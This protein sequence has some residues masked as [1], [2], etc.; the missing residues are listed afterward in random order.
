MR[1]YDPDVPPNPQEWNAL[2]ESERL[3]LVKRY[4]KSARIRLPSPMGHATFHVIV[5]NQV[6]M[7]D[8]LNVARTLER[9]MA[10]GLDRHDAL[11]A[12]G[13]VLA[14]HMNDLMGAGSSA[15]NESAYAADLDALTPETWSQMAKMRVDP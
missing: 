1:K 2:D 11:H 10:E 4:H 15:F 6:A 3:H 5:E 12:I 13:F 9:L 7:G 8:E 14:G